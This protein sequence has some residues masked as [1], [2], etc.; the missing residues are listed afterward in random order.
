MSRHNFVIIYYRILSQSNNLC[1]GKCEKFWGKRS[2]SKYITQKKGL[3]LAYFILTLLASAGGIGFA[4]VL[5]EVINQAAAG[6]MQGLIRAIVGG[7]FFL[8]AVIICEY[9]YDRVMNRMLYY[10]VTSLKNDLFC[11]YF[12]KNSADYEKDNSA[13]YINEITNN[14]NNFSDVY[15]SNV[16]ELPMVV[17][18]FV[19]AV[20]LCI[21]I[22]PMMLF[23]IVAFS[24]VI[25]IV[26][27]KCGQV[28]QNSTGAFA[29]GAEKY[30]SVIKDYFAGYRLIKNYNR[31]AAI[32][33]LHKEENMR[34]ERLRE[35]NSNNGSMYAR[36]NELLG[37]ASTLT[38][39]GV[40]GVFAVKGS[41]EIG[42][43]FAF[44]QLA[45]KIMQPI[46]QASGIYVQFQ[47]AKALSKKFDESLKSS[48]GNRE[49]PLKKS[50]F[51]S[52]ITVRKLSF[53][54]PAKKEN[55][56]ESGTTSV[57][58]S[59]TAAAMESGRD[60]MQERVLEDVS[61]TFLKGG[62][63][64]ITGKS[65]AG[66][67]TL[68]H[69]LAGLYDDYEGSLKYDDAEV[70]DMDDA[71][72]HS[73]VSVVSQEAFLF[74][75]TLKNN[76]TLYDD[77]YREEDIQRAVRLAGLEELVKRLSDGN[78]MGL[79]V[80]VSEN[81]SNF[82]GGEKQRINLARAI[83]RG[84]PV[85]LLDEFTASLDEK[86]ADEVERAVLELDGVTILFVTHKVNEKLAE[87]YD[88]RYEVEKVF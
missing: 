73:L 57:I 70:R 4:F 30:L 31:T 59:G 21:V 34:A 83:L 2:M 54:Y 45:G 10:A 88:G 48:M 13:Q 80:V 7:I 33:S 40:A 74:N 69:L 41:F 8:V 67:S 82:S 64:L 22:E 56:A 43:V 24:V 36:V 46:M 39:M 76:V 25:A 38:I 84:S 55:C 17:L 60:R 51:F 53:A 47:A 19:T 85:L 77:S 42:I 35:K 9:L 65:G 52:G 50:E 14:V 27:K 3:F 20:V 6:N 58:E 26:S 61:M 11:A 12:R 71:S 23:V 5:S 16:L 18:V 32:V 78:N 62:K 68:L 1:Y 81:G 86:T 15:F 49:K 37:L 87:R 28:L 72:L 63:Y 44:G 75:D 66:K 79:D 29:E